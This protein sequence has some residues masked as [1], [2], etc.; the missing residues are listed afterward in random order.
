MTKTLVINDLHI[1]AARSA[2]TTPATAWQL[3]TDLLD[4]YK[5]L[6]SAASGMDLL[7][8]GDFFDTYQIPFADM[9]GAL[10]L[11]Q[12]HLTS[13]PTCKAYF[14]AG[15]H[16]LSKD[17]TKMSSFEFFC[18]ILETTFPDRFCMIKGNKHF[19]DKYV[20]SHVVN[21]DLFNLELEQVPE[22]VKWLFLHCNFDN[23][24]AQEAD[25]SLNLS[26]SQAEKLTSRGINII[27][28]HEHQQRKIKFGK[29]YVHCLGNQMPSSVAD[30]L[31]N[32]NKIALVIDGTKASEIQTWTAAADFARVDLNDLDSFT[33]QQR[34]VRVEG[35]V[36]ADQAASAVSK[37]SKFRQASPALVITNAVRIESDGVELNFSNTLE[38]IKSFDVL[39]VLL[40]MLTDE[41]ADVVRNVMKEDQ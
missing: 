3:R 9:L 31:N 12:E 40:A 1:G 27:L 20:I 36:Q 6:L 19:G 8:N 21:Q 13:N 7:V 4:G 25:H 33:G 41:E 5:N 38:E 32:D 22:G 15:N 16:D 14:V 34:F 24:F 10:E 2:G 30:C 35:L 37:I 11:T 17:S 28:G 18:K 26:Q 39:N 23:H 29:N